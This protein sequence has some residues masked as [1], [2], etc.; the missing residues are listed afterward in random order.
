MESPNSSHQSIDFIG[1]G[2]EKCASTWL[3]KCLLEH[4][5][6]CGPREKELIYFDAVPLFGHPP[7]TQSRYERE[8]I[9]P[10]MEYFAHCAKEMVVGEFTSTY[11]HDAKA[12]KDIHA[13]FPD[14]KIIILL[15][16]PVDRAFSQYHGAPDLRRRYSTFEDAFAHEPELERRSRYAEYVAQYLSLFPKERVFIELYDRIE[17]DPTSVLRDVFTF[18]GV[19]A[20]VV[21]PS[22]N[23]PERTAA[24]KNLLT[25]RARLRALPLGTVLLRWLKAIGLSRWYRTLHAKTFRKPT[26]TP[27]TNAR[28][29]RIFREDIEKLEVLIQRDLAT[30]K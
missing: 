6:I 26:I 28:L 5:H 20:S 21:V 23:V 18:L 12:A 29:R 22:A 27:E 24:Q 15:R 25:T 7:R 3:F 30:W 13:V 8:G 17:S 4:P 19:D 1:V 11:L 2:G 16:N 14:T 9:G 10:F